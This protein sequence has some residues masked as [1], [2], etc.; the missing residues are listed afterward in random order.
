[1]TKLSNFRCNVSLLM[2]HPEHLVETSSSEHVKENTYI[3][4]M[5]FPYGS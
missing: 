2:Q 3:P 4:C 5:P 1:M